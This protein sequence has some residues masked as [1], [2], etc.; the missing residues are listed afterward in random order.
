M[1]RAA[2]LVAAEKRLDLAAC[3]NIGR[4]DGGRPKPAGACDDERLPS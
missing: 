4:R 1:A 3:P 2:R